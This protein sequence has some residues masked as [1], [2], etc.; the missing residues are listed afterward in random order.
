MLD[1]SF[2]IRETKSIDTPLKTALVINPTR[3]INAA[4]VSISYIQK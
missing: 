2:S 3:L 1:V 4:D